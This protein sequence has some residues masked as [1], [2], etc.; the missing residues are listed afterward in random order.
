[1][2]KWRAE[3]KDK[4]RQYR[5]RYVLKNPWTKHYNSARSRCVY[6]QYRYCQRG[7]TFHL[8]LSQVKELWFKHKAYLLKHP[9]I[10]RID[11]TKNYTLDNT[12]FIEL[13]LNIVRDRHRKTTCCK[14]GKKDRIRKD[15]CGR[16]YWFI[17]EKPRKAKKVGEK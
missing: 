14:C 5:K 7:I 12:R 15:L 4:I 8:T 13:N 2:K 11:S 1:M 3:N 16:C 6:P 9:S 17:V 10:D